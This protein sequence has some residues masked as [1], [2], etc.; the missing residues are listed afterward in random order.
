MTICVLNVAQ[1]ST[2][3]VG[4]VSAM[5]ATGVVG[6]LLS[7]GW[8]PQSLAFFDGMPKREVR[9]LLPG[10]A[11]RWKEEDYTELYREAKRQ[12]RRLDLEDNV[13]LTHQRLLFRDK[14][15]VDRQLAKTPQ[16]EAQMGTP[17]ELARRL[18]PKA[19]WT[20]RLQRLSSKVVGDNQR[21]KIEQGE[22]ER[23]VK[24]LH[25][26]LYEAGYLGKPDKE[27]EAMK[28]VATRYAMGRRAS[29]IRQHVRHARRIQEYMEG[30][31]GVQWLR[32]P[33]DLMMYIN[34]RLEEPCGRSVPGSLFKALVFMENA[35]E[36]PQEKRLS[37]SM[38][39]HHYLMEIEKSNIWGPRARQK[40][41]RF[42][43]EVLRAWEEGVM[44]TSLQ[45]YKRVFCWFKLL[46]LWGAL[47]AHDTE[48]VPPATLSWEVGVGLQGD[49]MRSKTTG[50]G[51]RVEVVQFHI[52]VNAWIF[53]REWLRVGYELFATMNKDAKSESRDFLMARPSENLHGF[54]EAMMRYPDAMA[55]SRA[56]LS[57]LPS[58]LTSRDG[59]RRALMSA[60]GTGFWSEHS[61]RVTMMSWALIA[62]VPKEVRRRWGR[63]SPSVD[64][65]Y[66]VTTKKVVLAAQG[67][68]AHK[69]KS[70]Y[71]TTDILDDKSV[72]NSYIR[73]LQESFGRTLEEATSTA[74][75][76]PPPMWPGREAG[77]LVLKPRPGAES[78]EGTPPVTPTSRPGSPTEVISDAEEEPD[79]KPESHYPKGAYILSMV[80]RSRRRTLHRGGPLP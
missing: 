30:V 36:L 9:G 16:G 47:R 12:R 33:K 49:I 54:A 60:E 19:T 17:M 52:S 58:S 61:E 48:G 72:I 51:R 69:I 24:E 76:L 56:L 41:N 11:E 77:G 57:E 35:A 15:Y 14:R 18:M 73:W 64:E 21:E 70:N 22:R 1:G 8:E 20:T 4:R 65:E 50:A 10:M 71:K 74:M 3:V 5:P 6:I 78:V 7:R 28:Y 25:E 53:E 34:A 67:G 38:A 27:F 26:L 37:T 59:R 2:R 62:E 79:H 43:L 39:L 29:T 42:P 68:V 66:A 75:P 63:W 40:A 46:K 80:G 32:H 55:Y 23:W 13:F 31:Y 44:N 45:K